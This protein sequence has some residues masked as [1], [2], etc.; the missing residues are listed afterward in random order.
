[1]VQMLD[2]AFSVFHPDESERG[3]TITAIELGNA[4]NTLKSSIGHPRII[5]ERVSVLNARLDTRHVGLQS[6]CPDPVLGGQWLMCLAHGI[7]GWTAPT[8]R[9]G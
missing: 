8:P 4:L 1:M 7:G 3:A 9:G 2:L 5:G 6:H